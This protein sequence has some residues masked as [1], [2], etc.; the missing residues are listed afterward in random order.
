ML[1]F[2][3]NAILEYRRRAQWVEK[4]DLLAAGRP[5]ALTLRTREEDCGAGGG[6]GGDAALNGQTA[7]SGATTYQIPNTKYTTTTVVARLALEAGDNAATY[8]AARRALRGVGSTFHVRIEAFVLYCTCCL[9]SIA[10]WASWLLATSR[11]VS[12]P[13]IAELAAVVAVVAATVCGVLVF[14]I[15]ANKGFMNAAFVVD[16]V[17]ARVR[18]GAVR[19]WAAWRRSGRVHGCFCL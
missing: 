2:T 9:L 19:A 4:L 13:M 14:G 18:A 5:V 16:S 11:P 10:A 8:I 7:S 17:R 15:R 1:P 6:L 12:V 3:K